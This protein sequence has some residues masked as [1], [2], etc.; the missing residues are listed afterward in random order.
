MKK[1]AIKWFKDFIFKNYY[2]RIGFSK[3]NSY[4][5]MK[6]QKKKDL[7]FLA[8]KLME[9]ILDTSNGKEYHNSYLKQKTRNWWK[10]KK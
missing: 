4:Y 2:G 9:E 6:H 5:S 7:L 1:L 8:I 10:N 3:G